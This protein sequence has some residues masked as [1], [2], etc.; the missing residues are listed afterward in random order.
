MFKPSLA[1]RTIPLVFYFTFG[2]HFLPAGTMVSADSLAY[3]NTE[4]NPRPPPVRVFYSYFIL[5]STVFVSSLWSVPSSNS[6]H[7]YLLQLLVVG[8]G[9]MCYLTHCNQPRYVVP[10][11]RPLVRDRLSIPDF[12]VL[13]RYSLWS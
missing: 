13:L 4:P 6:C 9:M 1:F 8:V 11:S 10:V 3:R 7:I 5:F 12:A 2:F